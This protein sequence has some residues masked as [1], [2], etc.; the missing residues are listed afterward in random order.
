M[1]EQYLLSIDNGTQSVRA[2]LFDLQGNLAAKAQVHLQAYYSEHPGWA[3]HDADGYWRAVG[4][5]C[6][7]LWQNCNVPR[8]PSKAWP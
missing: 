4:A 6:Q 8:T 3:E 5:A 2:L 1:A 7:Q